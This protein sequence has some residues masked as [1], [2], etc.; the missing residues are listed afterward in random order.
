MTSHLSNGQ[1]V[2]GK[3]HPGSQWFGFPMTVLDSHRHS[4]SLGEGWTGGVEDSSPPAVRLRSQD[5]HRVDHDPES[6][7]DRARRQELQQRGQSLLRD[8]KTRQA[9]E[10]DGGLENNAPRATGTRPMTR[11]HAPVSPVGVNGPAC[12]SVSFRRAVG[13]TGRSGPGG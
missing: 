4:E 8:G 10:A 13:S 1:L 3:G 2:R 6:P 11:H 12:G 9:T 7:Q 5:Q